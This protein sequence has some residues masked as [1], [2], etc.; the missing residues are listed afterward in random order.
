MFVL[1]W[2]NEH[3]AWWKPNECGYTNKRSEAGTYSI[4]TALLICKSANKFQGD[5]SIPNESICPI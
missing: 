4:A 2:S 3:K 1:I 5:D